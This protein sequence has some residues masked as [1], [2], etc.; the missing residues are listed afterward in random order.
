MDPFLQEIEDRIGS[1]DDFFM[2]RDYLDEAPIVLLGFA[3]LIDLAKTKSMLQKHIDHGIATIQTRDDMANGIGEVEMSQTNEM[4]AYM[5]QGKLIIYIED[6][7]RC[8]VLDPAPRLLNRA[9]DLPSNENVLQGPSYSFIEDLDTNVGIIRKEIASDKIRVKSFQSG[10][11]Q[12]KRLSILYIEGR[13][14]IHLINNILSQIE[15]NLDKEI[16]NLQNL[17]KMLGLTSKGI[18]S[19]FN[20]TELPLEAAHAL[21]Q[22]R[23]VL[24]VDRLPFALVLP[25]LLWDMFIM[26]N[27]RNYPLPIMVTIRTIRILGVLTTIIFPGLYIALVSVN[28]E[29][30]RIELALSIAQSR[31]GVPYPALIE[32]M[33]MLVILEFILEASVRLPRSIGPTITMVGGII[34]GQAVVQAKLVS[35]L[36]IIILAATTIANSTVVGFQNSLTIRYFKYLIAILAS[37][38]GVL[39]ILGGLVI[40]SAYLSNVSTF[41]TPYI[42]VN[43][44][45]G[46][47]NNG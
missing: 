22:G 19:K 3:S 30:L 5:I 20:T 27:D 43:H 44:K 36:L 8:I 39:G 21:R 14:D 24:F 45:K 2:K 28:P 47:M 35:N 26:E 11:E 18:I 7:L 9:V 29:V 1:N 41:G 37:I 17:S 12:S 6:D 4:I 25:V 10:N 13:A 16:N 31:S 40:V 46:E 23:V 15:S 34:L 33:L 42:Q 38:F 32:M